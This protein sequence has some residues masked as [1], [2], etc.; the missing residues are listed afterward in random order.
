MKINIFKSDFKFPEI[1]NPVSYNKDSKN[2]ET[3][4]KKLSTDKNYLK[5]EAHLLA[6]EVQEMLSELEKKGIIK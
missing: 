4:L 6:D 1:D 5:E 2:L 3:Y